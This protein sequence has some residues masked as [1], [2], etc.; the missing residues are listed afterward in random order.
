MPAPDKKHAD[1]RKF[2]SN[3]RL[4]HIT[5]VVNFRVINVHKKTCKIYI[6][7]L[8]L[9]NY[10]YTSFGHFVILCYFCTFRMIAKKSCK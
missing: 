1:T 7:F 4:I 3:I 8:M 10:K 2:D 6:A 5:N 9:K